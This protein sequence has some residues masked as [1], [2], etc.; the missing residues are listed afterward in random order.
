M[1]KENK[2][3]FETAYRTGTDIWSHAPIPEKARLLSEKLNKDALILDLGSGRGRLP[4]ELVK[5]GFRL[6]GVDYVSDIVKNNNKE[7]S[8]QALNDRL[9]FVEADVLELPFTDSGFDA[10]VD[11]GLLQHL[12][13]KDFSNYVNEV[14]RMIKSGG[15]FYLFVLSRETSHFFTWHPKES[16][17]GTFSQYGLSYHFFTKDELQKLFEK[18]FT[19]ESEKIV[20]VLNGVNPATYIEV[21]LRKK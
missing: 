2:Q 19:L 20:Q 12:D 7:V 3:F 14:S 8:G 21:L 16:D 11:V 5:L 10:V 18:N 9:R 4:F 6:I 13:L 17:T 15:Y 1:Q